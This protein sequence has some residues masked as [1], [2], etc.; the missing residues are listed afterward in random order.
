MISDV[1]MNEYING[2]EVQNDSVIFGRRDPRRIFYS[3]LHGKVQ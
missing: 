2:F 1:F 3:L